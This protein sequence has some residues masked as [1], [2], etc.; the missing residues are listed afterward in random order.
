MAGVNLSRWAVQRPT[1]MLFLMI[2]ISLTGVYSYMRLGRAEDPSFTIKVAVVTASWPGATATEIRDQVADLMEKKL[3]ELPFLDKIETYA[4]PGFLAMQVTLKDTTPPKDVPQLFY[5][6]RKK[7]DDI[8]PTLPAGVR[9][10]QVN[11]E[12]GDVDTVMYAVTGDGADYHVLDKVVQTL[13]Q[14]LLAVQDVTKVEVYGDQGRRIFVEF[15]EAKLASLAILPQA[16]FDSLVKQNAINDAGVFETSSNRVRVQVTS[17]L[18]GADAIAAIPIEANGKVIRLGDIANVY[19]GFEDPPN[20]LAR[21]KGQPAIV[22]GVVMGKGANVLKFGE[23]VGAAVQEIRDKTPVG[24]DIDQV[25]D[26]PKVVEEAVG[27]FTR[28]FLEALVIVLGVS[29]IS[30]GFRTGIVVALSV[31]LVLAIVFIFMG[32]LGIDLQR[33]SLGALIIALGLLVDDAIIAVEMMMV[34]MEQGFN[35]IKAATFAWDST[36]FPM[37]TGTLVTA[38]GFLPVGF[39]NSAVGEYTGSMFWVLLVALIASWFVAV[40][41]TPYLGVKLLPDFTK[42][43]PHRDPD[44][45]YRTPF[46]RWLRAVV[47]WAVDCRGVVIAGVIGVFALA[48]FGFFVVPKQFFPYAERLELFLQLRLPEGSS[49]GASLEA[50]KQAETL[51]KD[52]PDA[53]LYTSYVGQGPP[54]FWLGLNPQL[55]NE[56]YS[57]IV[58]VAKDIAA[59]ER[60]KKKL[61]TA[62]ANGA[63]PQARARVDRFYYGP[64]VGFPVQFRVVGS[65]PATV[66][67]I[68]YQVRDVMRGDEGVDDPHLNWNEQTP[69]VR[70]VIDQDRARLLGLT[71]QDVSNRLRLAISG[72]TITTLRDGID[73]VEVVARAVPQERGDLSRIGDM[74]VYARDGKAVTVSQVAKIVYDHEEP[75]FWRRNR[76][77]SITV[78]SGVKDGVQAPDATTRIWPRLAQIR[79]HLPP[80][81]R[82]EVGGAI[83]ESKKGNASIFAVFPLVGLVMLTIVMFQ[84]QN[85]TRVALVMMSAP[86]GVVGASLALN[87]AHAPFGFVALLGLIALSGMDM[88]NSIILVDQVRQDLE[89]GEKYREAI[90]GA[91]IR[92]VRPVALT[93]LAAILAMIPLSGSAF[94]GPM[95]LTIMG[96]L[97]VATFLTVLFLPALYATWFRRHLGEGLVEAKGAR[98]QTLA[99][100]LARGAAE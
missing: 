35:R 54:R 3:Q 45:I 99:D 89:R 31:P 2:A 12:Y 8:A 85:F 98:A 93:A 24:I 18:K 44:E 47:T 16:V 75:I 43:H 64:P 46:Y 55:P 61:E 53:A 41:F 26:Q 84:L 71:P 50:A 77:M 49:I 34:K 38:A 30:L 27:E 68:A 36:A 87:V 17:D 7:L 95:A 97:F 80:G 94:W 33:I 39:A 74:V 76:D 13:R 88:R 4:K 10:P 11:D 51:L 32:P 37:L 96:G 6:L 62:I 81:Y 72:V 19:A 28:S 57:E 42:L 23:N 60:L 1:L 58:I 5:Q 86:L 20:F 14:R 21:F 66:R 9:G 90:I 63:L 91:T 22:V 92:R 56:A 25:A 82:I 67:A 40:M 79:E 48:V 52:D 73:Q 15:S 59:R 83:E 29:F 100:G 69:R 78:R 65:D 70:L